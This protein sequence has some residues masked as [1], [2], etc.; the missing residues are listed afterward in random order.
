[1]NISIIMPW[2]NRPDLSESLERNYSKFNFSTIEIVIVNFGG[3][4]ELI[5]KIIK[6]S[7]LQNIKLI[8]VKSDMFNK[9]KAINIG[10]NHA[11]NDIIF[12]LDCD[13]VI[14]NNIH[15]ITTLLSCEDSFLTL[16]KTTESNQQNKENIEGEIKEV[17][18]YISFKDKQN[19]EVMVETNRMFLAE[20]ARSCPGLVV[21]KK[22]IFIKIGG[23]NSEL[24]GWGWE[25]IDLIYRLKF[26]GIKRI[27]KGNCIHL[28]HSDDK[29]FFVKENKAINE[30]QNFKIALTNYMIG[31]YYGTYNNDVK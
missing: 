20:N 3:K 11:K 12:I 27:K 1:M 9:S 4:I 26:H 2:S 23:M 16:E 18:H 17:A 21:L 31:N 29:R 25:D 14:N 6:D 28:S 7:K 22:S 10:V 8:H 13:I 24:I 5:E 15:K 19:K 30:S